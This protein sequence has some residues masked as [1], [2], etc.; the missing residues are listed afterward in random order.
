MKILILFLSISAAALGQLTQTPVIRTG[1]EPPAVGTCN[2]VVFVGNLYVRTANPSNSPIGVFR[3]TQVG[4]PSRGA[5]AYGWQPIG[6][7]AGTNLPPACTLGDL[8]F[9]TGPGGGNVYGCTATN[10]WTI[11]SVPDATGMNTG[12]YCLN[13][14]SGRV[15]G[16]VSCSGGPPS[17]NI[18]WSTL[19][20][21]Q[22]AALTS[23]QWAT[24]A[25]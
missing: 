12:T 22:W 8:A 3:C 20:S 7:V 15:T 25:P 1:G 24:L 5:A 10:T 21:S 17:G 9:L 14:V 23:A 11:Q 16:L 4:P 2:D 13:V 18:L 6:H 19:T